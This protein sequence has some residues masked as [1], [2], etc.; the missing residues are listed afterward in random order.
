MNRGLVNLEELRSNFAN[1]D[2][3]QGKSSYCFIQGDKIIKVYATKHGENFIPKNI[4][5]FS[6]FKADTIVFPEAYIYEKGKVVGEISKYIKSKPISTSFD[7]KANIQKIIQ[8]YEK[9]LN[10]I[11]LYK[12]INMNDLCYVN[13][14]YSNR[15]G[16]HIIDTTEWQLEENAL[17]KNIYCFNMS[18]IDALVEYLEIPIVYSRYYSVVDD[19]YMQNIDKYGQGGKQL[20]ANIELLMNNKYNFLRFLYSYIDAYR[21]Y[22]GADAKTF[23]DINEFTKVLKKS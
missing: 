14:L 2:F 3:K 23:N 13:I 19:K 17:K 20:R 12:D 5:D 7:D 8:S 15:L 10:D 11:Y 9:V 18:L 4:C 22:S 16:F 21:A 1:A 6:N